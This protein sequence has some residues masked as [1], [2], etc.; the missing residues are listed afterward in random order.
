MHGTASGS[1]IWLQ[2]RG[3]PFFP[4]WFQLRSLTEKQQVGADHWLGSQLVRLPKEPPPPLWEFTGEYWEAKQKLDWS[5]CP[6][7][8]SGGADS[9]PSS[10][11]AST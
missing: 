8:Y 3:Q 2:A 4:V 11:R 7:I 9:S 6:D 5:R 10:K 1:A